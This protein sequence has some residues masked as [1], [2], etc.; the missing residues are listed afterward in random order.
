ME[1][2]IKY[3]LY[4]IGTICG[5][6]LTSLVAIQIHSIYHGGVTYHGQSRKIRFT[7]NGSKRPGWEKEFYIFTV[8]KGP[9]RDYVNR[10]LQYM[11]DTDPLNGPHSNTICTVC[12]AHQDEIVVKRQ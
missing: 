11:V 8:T 2:F 9:G 12:G 7:Q 1:G 6:G 10:D 3:T 5:L 4:G